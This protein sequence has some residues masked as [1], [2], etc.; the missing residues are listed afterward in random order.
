LVFV[1]TKVASADP[2]AAG[3]VPLAFVLLDRMGGATRAGVDMSYIFPNHVSL[4]GE[5]NG[6]AGTSLRFDVHG[7]YFHPGTGLGVYVQ[8]PFSHVGE[9]GETSGLF[10]MGG[11]SA[12]AVGDIEV[13]GGFL[14]TTCLMLR[15]GITLPTGAALNSAD[16][17]FTEA[18]YNP[19]T[20]SC[21]GAYARISDLYQGI[22]KGTSLRLSASPMTR[23]GIVFMRA[24]LGVD[25]NLSNRGTICTA[26]TLMRVSAGLGLDLGRS[27]VM[28]ESVN[29]RDFSISESGAMWW[30]VIAISARVNVGRWSP[31]GALSFALNDGMY[32]LGFYRGPDS[33]GV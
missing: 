20:A 4:P 12:N 16:G 6:G 10:L 25:A 24:D 5:S 11:G 8:V 9:G 19:A 15:A 26:H 30:N 21:V 17:N 1:T 27:S 32:H 23:K 13:G 33:N 22:G 29:L 3:P 2:P 14:P 31:Y 18:D 28:L 7:E